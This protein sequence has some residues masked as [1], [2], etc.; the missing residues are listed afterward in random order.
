[1]I[2]A[3]ASGLPV[4]SVTDRQ[5]DQLRI[6]RHGEAGL[7]VPQADQE[8]LVR[9][10][11]RLA[12]DPALRRTFGARG[13]DRAVKLFSADRLV[14][15]TEAIYSQL[16]GLSVLRTRPPGPIDALG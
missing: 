12:D 16:L 1:M 11:E 10:V 6:V 13:R 2:E 9:A 14:R 15:Q 3:M 5:P 4:I 8:A 7:I